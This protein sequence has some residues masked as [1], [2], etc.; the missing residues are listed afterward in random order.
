[1]ELEAVEEELR[2]LVA[3]LTR[4]EQFLGLID[5]AHEAEF[6][7]AV[8]PALQADAGDAAAVP[9]PR[10]VS[11]DPAKAIPL[12]LRALTCYGVREHAD[13]SRQLEDGLLAPDQ[14]ARV[15]RAVYEELLWLAD[16]VIRRGVDHHS[17][18][19][20]APQ[21][22]AREGLAYLRQAETALGPTSA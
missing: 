15:R 5:R 14:V 16:N 11:R 10:D 2:A 12:L 7:R 21:Q 4:F 3:S 17:G 8:A 1:Q 13:W 20:V 22:A 19:K 9:E 6:P 18:Q